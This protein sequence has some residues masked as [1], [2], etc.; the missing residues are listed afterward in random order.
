[1]YR[2]AAADELTESYPVIIDSGA[3]LVE[4]LDIEPNK[5]AVG[6]AEGLLNAS[7]GSIDAPTITEHLDNRRDEATESALLL[8]SQT[9]ELIEDGCLWGKVRYG[10]CWDL[11]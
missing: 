1:M 7:K 4:C 5:M 11:S 9:P 3:A 2:L 10:N 8:R 6:A